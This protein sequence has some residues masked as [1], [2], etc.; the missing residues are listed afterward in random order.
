MSILS[1]SFLLVMLYFLIRIFA[2]SLFSFWRCQDNVEFENILSDFD[3]LLG[4]TASSNSLIKKGKTTAEVEGI[5]LEDLAFLHNYHQLI[6]E[7]T[8][9]LPQSN[10]CIDLIF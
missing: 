2:P 9:L 4:K 8:H 5:H 7:L 10:S 6:S 3:Q 1:L